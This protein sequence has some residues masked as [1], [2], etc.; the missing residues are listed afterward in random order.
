MIV[1]SVLEQHAIFEGDKPW[2]M[3]GMLVLTVLNYHS[4]GGGTLKDLAECKANC[5][6]DDPRLYKV[7]ITVAYE[8]V[9]PTE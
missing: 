3:D 8:E 1:D 2:F 7:R 5:S 6:F 4:L 9:K